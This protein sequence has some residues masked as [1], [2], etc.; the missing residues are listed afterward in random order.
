LQLISLPQGITASLSPENPIGEIYRYTV[1]S[2]Q[3]DLIQEKEIQ[4]WVLE[5]QLKTVP[6]VIDVAGFGGLTKEYHVEVDP[7]KLVHL[8]IPLSTLISAIQNSNTNAAGNYLTLGEQAF[9]VRG[10]GFIQTLDDIRRIVL[11]ASNSTPIR[12]GDLAT[13]KSVT[14]PGSASLE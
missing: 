11:T 7:E 10:I 2:P 3:H 6:G 9:D 4:D 1:E 8:Q 12:V 5:K 13:L 14:R